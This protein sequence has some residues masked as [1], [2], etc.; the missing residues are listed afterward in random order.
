MYKYDFFLFRLVVTSRNWSSRRLATKLIAL[1]Y[2]GLHL[3]LC[4]PS[5]VDASVNTQT[6]QR[7]SRSTR[8]R[9]VCPTTN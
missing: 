4:V 2:P 8:E 6:E 7:T 1:L 9:Q 5:E 3:L